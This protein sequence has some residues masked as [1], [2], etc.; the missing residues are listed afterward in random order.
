[1][2]QLKEI[3]Q[4]QTE[5]EN[6]GIFFIGQIL[7]TTVNLLY[8]NGRLNTGLCLDQISAFS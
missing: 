5:P 7:A 8:M 2:E 6:F 1:M 3:T 4:T